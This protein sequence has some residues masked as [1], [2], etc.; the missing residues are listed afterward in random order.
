MI[1]DSE[2]VDRIKEELK[3]KMQLSSMWI[4]S[5]AI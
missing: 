5:K 2:L 1:K 4:Q 3:E